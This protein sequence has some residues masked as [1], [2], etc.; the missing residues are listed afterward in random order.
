MEFAPTR[1]VVARSA[2]AFPT[3]THQPA[4]VYRRERLNMGYI[5]NHS[6]W[7]DLPILYQ[8]IGV[9]L[10]GQGAS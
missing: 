4:R 2:P 3:R 1:A 7:L 8:T 6:I 10:R 5:R 9:V